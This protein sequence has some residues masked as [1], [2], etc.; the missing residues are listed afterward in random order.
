MTYSPALDDMLAIYARVSTESQIN[1]GSVDEQIDKAQK[2]AKG[3]WI[4]DIDADGD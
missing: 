3:T 2:L 4:F 1:N